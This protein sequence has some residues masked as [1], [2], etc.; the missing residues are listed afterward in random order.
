MQEFIGEYVTVRANLAGCFAG[1]VESI[2]S[3]NA[4]GTVNVVLSESRQLWRWWTPVGQGVA[5]VAEHGLASN[6]EV[7]VGA[8]QSGPQLIAS[9]FQLNTCTPAAEA[10]IR[11]RSPVQP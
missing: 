7:R 8:Q 1:K 6:S 2:A 11:T 4:D 5:G 10:S 3:P 9:V